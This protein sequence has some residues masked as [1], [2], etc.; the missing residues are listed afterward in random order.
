MGIYRFRTSRVYQGIFWALRRGVL[1]FASAVFL[2]WLGAVAA[3]HFLFNVA[4]SAGAFCHETNKSDIQSL[5][6]AKAGEQATAKLLFKAS[7]LCFAT[8]VLVE[9][10]AKYSVTITVPQQP[11][12][13]DG[14]FATTPSGFKTA[15]L[16]HWWM[17]LAMVATMPMRRV[18]FRRW[19]T[20]IARIGPT[21]VYEDFLDPV[22]VD[23]TQN[24]YRGSTQKAQRSGELFLYV[25]EAVV[26]LPWITDVLYRNNKGEAQVVIRRL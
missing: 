16:P 26:A 8:G 7:D 12:F 24:V 25:N 17:K 14:T 9:K 19:F 20:V 5:E 23:G 6:K 21:G 15:E 1:P 10:G 13:A 18:I 2:L 22:R 3:N 11:K 4:D